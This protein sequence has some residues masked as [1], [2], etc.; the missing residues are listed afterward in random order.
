MKKLLYIFLG[1]SL[2]F[3][4]SD[5][6]DSDSNEPC[7]NQP[8]LTTNEVSEIE[9]NENTDLTNATFSGEIQNIQLGA[10]CETFSITNQGFVYST[11]VQPTT[12]DIVV[13]V[14]G[15]NPSINITNFPAETTYYVR[16]YLTN[17][18]G[19]FYGNEVSFTTPQSTNPV[20]LAENGITIKA[21]DWANIG[22]SGIIAGV[23]YLIIDEV[24]LR[25]MV[26]NL[27]NVTN[28]CTTKIENMQELFNRLGVTGDDGYPEFN[29]DISSWD[30]S[31]VTNMYGMF[32]GQELFNQD[33]SSWDVSNVTNM[34]AIF[35]GKQIII[36]GGGYYESDFNQDISS[37]DVSNVTNMQSMFV[38]ASSF[39]QNIGSWDVN[40]VNSMEAMFMEAYSFNQD[41]SSWDVSNVTSMTLL[42][43]NGAFFIP[44]PIESSFNQD[45]SSWD[46]SSL[47]Q[48]YS[49]CGGTNNWTLPKPNFPNNCGDS[50][51]D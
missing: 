2:I 45:L 5:D 3:A 20:Y 29:Q 42:F 32:A 36:D 15:Q 13:N 23:E 50:L 30:V 8:Q 16:A 17:S 35:V 34:Q 14:N 51:C 46:V 4:C 33:I 10:N 21:R 49:V 38:G 40:N 25:T 48:C 28:I 31:N 18:L 7:P 27:E 1:L 24:D 9:Y 11:T 43:Y 37:W 41:I 26:N 19:T 6:G 39:N 22:D 12:S 47:S 44:D